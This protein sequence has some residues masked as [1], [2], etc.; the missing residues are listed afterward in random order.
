MIYKGLGEKKKTGTC[1]GMFEIKISD[2]DPLCTH[3]PDPAPLGTDVRK[4]QE[5]GFTLRKQ[6]FQVNNSKVAGAVC[7]ADGQSGKRVQ[8]IYAH[9]SDRGSSYEKYLPDIKRIALFMDKSFIDSAAKTKGYRYIRFAHDGNCEPIIDNVRI[10]SNANDNFDEMVNELRSMGYNRDDRKYVVWRDTNKICG[11][12]NL[13]WNDDRPGLDNESNA[14]T[15][16]AFIDNGCWGI[17]GGKAEVHELGHVLGAVK[18]SVPHNAGDGH[19]TDPYDNMCRGTN[20]AKG[21]VMEVCPKTQDGIFDCKNDD[22]FSTNPLEGSYLATH[23]NIANSQ[24]LGGEG[25]AEPEDPIYTP[26]PTPKPATPTPTKKPITPTPTNLPIGGPNP[27]GAPNPTAPVP[28]WVCGGSPDSVCAT[29][30]P[31][32]RPT[33]APNTPVPTNIIPT[34]SLIEA[35]NVTPPANQEPSDDCLDPRSTP[36]R[37]N[38]WVQ[39]FLKKIGDYIQSIFGNPQNPNP[40]PQPCIIR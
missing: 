16:F 21:K 32:P 14:K 3:G 28:T 23:W 26:T 24:F 31:S 13:S 11:L 22:Y 25:E 30:A 37:I 9:P 40:P 34:E 5:P 6:V 17:E 4:R 8:L 1:K 7:E 29:S 20:T 35:P 19:C 39:G 27:T 10:S 15:G 36:E 12:A 18:S 38:D 2:G 33:F